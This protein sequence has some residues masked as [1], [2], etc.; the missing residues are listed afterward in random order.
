[1]KHR[2]VGVVR[3]RTV[4]D[5]SNKALIDYEAIADWHREQ[6]AAV[7]P[8]GVDIDKAWPDLQQCFY[9][10]LRFHHVRTRKRPLEE[11]KRWEEITRLIDE[12]ASK[13]RTVNH[14]TVW[15]DFDPMG[16]NRLLK[17][18]QKFR[19][20]AEL[21][22]EIWG[23]LSGELFSGKR[24]AH[25]DFLHWG[26]LRAWTDR[27]GGRLTTYSKSD[28]PRGPLIDF[29]VACVTPI[30]PDVPS[31]HTVADIINRERR[32]RLGVIDFKK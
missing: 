9:G 5:D 16:S 15:K 7:L 19:L 10:F 30:L 21:K 23:P 14:E 31:P 25:R 4:G 12:L 26:I 8:P 24:N 11:R 17:E 2:I 13:V 28:L 18:L 29:F 32:N 3:H 20:K 6:V 27:L 22:I 1:M